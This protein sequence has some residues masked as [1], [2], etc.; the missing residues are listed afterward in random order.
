MIIC[1][2]LV[3]YSLRLCVLVPGVS[4][5]MVMLVVGSCWSWCSH[6]SWNIWARLGPV[7]E[8][9][10]HVSPLIWILGCSAFILFSLLHRKSNPKIRAFMKEVGFGEDYKKLES[11]YIQR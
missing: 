7:W 10:G 8:G 5:F 9:L 4:V 1:R 6:S 3:S 2:S 11:F